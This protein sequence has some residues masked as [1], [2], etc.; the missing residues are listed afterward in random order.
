[1]AQ[2]Q[3]MYVAQPQQQQVQVAQPVYDKDVT[4]AQ[5]QPVSPPAGQQMIRTPDGQTIMVPAG[6][7]VIFAPANGQQMPMQYQQP[8]PYGN[9]YGQQ[10]YYANGQY[11]PRQDNSMLYGIFGCLAACCL[12]DAAF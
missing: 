4:P 12:L 3:G 6:A 7:Q 10:P 2:N 8:G 5:A 11:P 9:Q 1:M